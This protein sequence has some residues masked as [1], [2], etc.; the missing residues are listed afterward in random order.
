MPLNVSFE[1]MGDLIEQL[2]LMTAN[3]SKVENDALKEAM[4]PIVEDAKQTTAFHDRTRKLRKSL[5][6]GKVQITK[7]R[8]FIL[9]GVFDQTVFYGRMVE[10]GTSRAAAR[11]FL[12][13]AFE[14]RQKEAVEIIANRIREALKP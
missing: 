9:G 2:G 13:P 3:A 5:A 12:G 4:E 6:V 10:F 11:P 14:R 1:G 7:G 8:K